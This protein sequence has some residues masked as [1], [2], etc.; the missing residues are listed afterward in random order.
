[1]AGEP[2]QSG[3][4]SYKGISR[5]FPWTNGSSRTKLVYSRLNITHPQKKTQHHLLYFRQK[6]SYNTTPRLLCHS[7]PNLIMASQ[8]D[9]SSMLH[10]CILREHTQHSCHHCS[11]TMSCNWRDH[12]ATGPFR[13]HGRNALS[14]QWLPFLQ[15][16]KEKTGLGQGCRM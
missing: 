8:G 5:C 1:M 11:C 15:T 16:P 14:P 3:P 2:R 9:L 12:T 4:L 13:S 10:T 7:G 6:V